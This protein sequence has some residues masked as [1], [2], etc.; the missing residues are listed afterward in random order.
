VNW[1]YFGRRRMMPTTSAQ[2]LVE[3]ETINGRKVY[4]LLLDRIA[5]HNENVA[6]VALDGTV[7]WDTPETFDTFQFAG[8]LYEV[9]GFDRARRRAWVE[10]VKIIKENQYT[11][12]GDHS[13]PLAA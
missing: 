8:T 1:P 4:F 11:P 2:Q 3:W 12:A 9:E 7:H 10:P 6:F 13:D 5:K